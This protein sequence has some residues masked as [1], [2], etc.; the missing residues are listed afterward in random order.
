LSRPETAQADRLRIAETFTSVQGEGKLTGVPSHF[1][2]ISGCNLRCAWC[3][4]P[5]ASWDAEGDVVP[6]D[7]L[8]LRAAVSRVRHVVLTGGEPMLFPAIERLAAGLRAGGMHIT[9]ETAGTV[10]REVACDL[11]SLSPKL[12]N[13]TPRPGDPRDPDGAWRSRH[14]SRRLNV[15]VVQSLLDIYPERQIKFVVGSPSDLP[16]I[17]ALLSKLRGVGPGDVML[18]PEGVRPPTDATSRWIG[19]ACARR[20]WRYCRRLHIDLFGNVRG[21]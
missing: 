20:G 14:E 17:E 18:M 1:V 11:L 19:E 15:R 12:A 8:V 13:S 10:F 5:F 21:T 3:D 4:T 6:V 2:R 16:E 9:I 7:D